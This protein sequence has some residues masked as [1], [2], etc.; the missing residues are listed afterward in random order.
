MGMQR[1]HFLAGMGVGFAAAVVRAEA[2]TM[3]VINL[4]PMDWAT[5]ASELGKSL[6]TPNEVFFIRSHMG[7]PA[8]INAAAWRLTIDGLVDRPLRLSLEE[9]KKFPKHEVPAILQCSGNGRW[10]YGEAYA[11]V[12][13]PAGAQWRIG[14]VGNARWAGARVKD[15][16]AKAGVKAAARFSTNFGL[17]NPILP[18]TPKF[19]RGIE[20]EKL[21]DDDTILA[22][23]MNGS[24]LP[25]YHGY[26]VRLLVPGWAADHS[27][28]WLTNMT[29]ADSLTSNFWT[30]V[31]YRYPNKLGPPGKG[32]KPT[33]EHPVT[34][35]NVKSVILSPSEAQRAT[36]GSPLT[37]SGFAWSGDGAHAAAV[38]V[39]VDGG[40]TFRPATLGTLPGK[41]SWR[42]FS[43][44]FTPSS[45][46]R[47]RIMTRARDD[48]GAVQ[49]AV[50]PWNPGGYLW[51]AMPVVDVE[52]VHA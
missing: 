21:L 14:G 37:V 2:S 26:P 32:V 15:V 38:D 35:L 20:L 13:H 5:P 9:L 39:S 7:P 18:T 30:A 1:G 42:S 41:F 48:R 50:S 49:P 12:S 28:K 27:V 17:D 6:Y 10:Y 22:Y 44:Q 33:N 47:L 25:Y 46:G 16:L 19:I 40:R 11:D 31:G 43:F 3:D 51:N 4:R 8:S 45:P 23:E 34:A 36:A 52:V 24:P 29:L